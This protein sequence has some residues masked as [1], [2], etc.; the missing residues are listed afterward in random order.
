M[1]NKLPFPKSKRCLATVGHSS[2][3]LSAVHNSVSTP[4]LTNERFALQVYTLKID[5]PGDCGRK[6]VSNKTVGLIL[7]LGILFGNLLKEKPRPDIPSVDVN[8]HLSLE[9]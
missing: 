8:C 4:G 3:T 2:N 1:L 5:N 6:F 9:K 7:F